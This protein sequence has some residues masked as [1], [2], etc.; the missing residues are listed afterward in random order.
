M[1]EAFPFL[2]GLAG[3]R[4]AVWIILL[5]GSSCSA[6]S[7]AVWY[8][9]MIYGGV[10]TAQALNITYSAFLVIFMALPP[11]KVIPGAGTVVGVAIILAGALIVSY[12][13]IRA[14]RETPA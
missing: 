12:E 13:S 4:A 5:I 11:F 8:F 3:N 14:D 2:S 10:G 9:S 1:P 7:Y 6:V